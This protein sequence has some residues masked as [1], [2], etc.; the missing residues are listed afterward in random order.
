MVNTLRLLDFLLWFVV[1]PGGLREGSP[2][3]WAKK[4]KHLYCRLRDRASG[5]EIADFWSLIGPS[6]TAKPTGEGGGRSAPP[7]PMGP[8]Q[9]DDFWPANFTG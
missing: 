4:R 1:G 9:I 3:V 7:F 5:Q 6:L 2:R 8:P